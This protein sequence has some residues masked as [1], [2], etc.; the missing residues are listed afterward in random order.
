MNA[1]RRLINLQLFANANTTADAGMSAEMKTFYDKQ[2][3]RMAG[4]HLIHDQFAQQKDIPKNGGK[5]IEFRK[6]DPLPKAMTPL[7]EGVTPNGRKM[8]VRTITAEV[9]QY[10]DYIE[11]TDV[12]ELTSI[13]NNIVEA[14]NLL[15]DQ[16][17][18]TL[19]AITRDAIAAGTN[20][21]YAGGKT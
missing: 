18:R 19:D 9:E 16:S 13:D 10:G 6:Y 11:L 14:T 4:P 17:G 20:V 5:V 1:N 12:L 21:I 2:L 8:H 7:T 15:G 3:I